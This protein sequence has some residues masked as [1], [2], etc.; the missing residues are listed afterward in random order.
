MTIYHFGIRFRWR[1]DLYAK[2]S[3]VLMAFLLLWIL[4]YSFAV[5]ASEAADDGLDTGGPNR[6]IMDVA[7]W[8]TLVLLLVWGLF[9][10][11]ALII[12]AETNE[13]L[14]RHEMCFLQH[15][16]GVREKKAFIKKR[17]IG[18]PRD[19]SLQRLPSEDD[20]DTDPFSIFDGRD[21]SDEA[22]NDSDSVHNHL[23]NAAMASVRR[24]IDEQRTAAELFQKEE[25]LNDLFETAVAIIEANSRVEPGRFLGAHA[26]W[27][28]VSSFV[29][30]WAALLGMAINLA[31]I[32]YN[33]A[34]R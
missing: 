33:P 21:A 16:L 18:R 32:T 13:E 23:A 27:G 29:L 28:L 25:E 24:K 6:L 9:Y 19:F 20:T 4:V 1:I 3:G 2:V 14:G 17:I 15:R 31:G 22:Q 8:Y 34:A 30:A 12:L 11:L 26:T 10:L 5:Q 7:W